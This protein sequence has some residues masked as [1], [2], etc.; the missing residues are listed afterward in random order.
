MIFSHFLQAAVEQELSSVNLSA[1]KN[2]AEEL[3]KRYKEP[4]QRTYLRF[5]DKDAHR[6]A[7]IA[8][9]MPATFSV[10]NKVLAEMKTHLP[11]TYFN[12]LL[13]LGS[14]P[15]TALFAALSIFREIELVTAIEEDSFLIALAKR[16]RDRCDLLK[17]YQI[18]WKE[19]DIS[20]QIQY[21][22][23]DLVIISYAIGEMKNDE[24]E[25]NLISSAW[26]AAS[27]ALVLIEPGTPRGF[28]CIRRAR[29]RLIR[30]GAKI[31]AP[32][33]HENQCPMKDGNWCHFSARL[34]RSSMHRKIKDG[35]LGYEDEKFSYVIA[36]KEPL[37]TS[38]CSRILRHPK[39]H[40]GHIEFCLC[41]P[42]GLENKTISKRQGALYKKARKLEWGDQL[43]LE[44]CLE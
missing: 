2:A 12:S 36:T 44:D 24:S 27:K 34:E 28:E 37:Q 40:S 1:L 22:P 25:K 30:A 20:C 14:G 32:C 21:D 9:R 35:S 17:L 31:A 29:E 5:I 7:Y 39:K 26:S 41:S 18:A 13:D 43:S 8:Y 19:N 38:L 16:L 42:E 6:K 33:P 3:T 11:E 4:D 15:G 23:H 10:V